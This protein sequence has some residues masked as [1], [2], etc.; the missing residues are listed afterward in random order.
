LVLVFVNAGEKAIASFDWDDTIDINIKPQDRRRR[1]G[2]GL[3]IG[4]SSFAK[5]VEVSI[6]LGSGRSLR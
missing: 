2:G 5:D 3:A 6:V 1:L 4:L